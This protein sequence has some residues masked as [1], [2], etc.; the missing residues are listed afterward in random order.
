MVIVDA[1]RVAVIERELNGARWYL[2]PGGGVDVDE[3][4][5][6]AAIRE[7]HEELGLTV[8]LVGVVAEVRFTRGGR[9]SVQTYFAAKSSAGAFGTGTGSEFDLPEDSPGGSYTPMWLELRDASQ[10]D[11]RPRELFEA[12]G[13]RGVADLLRAP[14]MID[15][16]G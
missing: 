16:S 8:A 13:G 3:T 11:V 14:L 15:E 7:A 1:R 9:L 4:V 6:A 5:K 12:L 2:F 10:L